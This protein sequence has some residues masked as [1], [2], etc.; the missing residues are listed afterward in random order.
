MKE[1]KLNHYTLPA[2][3]KWQTI[4]TDLDGLSAFEISGYA[5][6][7]KGTGKYCVVHSI[8]LNAYKGK[9]GR[10]HSKYDYY[11]CRQTV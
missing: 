6:G 3:G 7:I 11:G 9:G 5:Q 1:Q 8:V 10:M 4:L 2:D